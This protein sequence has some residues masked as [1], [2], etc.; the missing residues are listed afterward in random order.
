[1]Q[2]LAISLPKNHTF[3]AEIQHQWSSSVANSHFN[4]IDSSKFAKMWICEG[5]GVSLF[6]KRVYSRINSRSWLIAFVKVCKVTFLYSKHCQT[7]SQPIDLKLISYIALQPP[8]DRL[9][10]EWIIAVNELQC[11]FFF[12]QPLYNFIVFNLFR[13]FTVLLKLILKIIVSE[14]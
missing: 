9:L 7:T 6:W 13:C 2:I 8:I 10:I 1:M 11:S 14:N 4:S 3:K 12:S 5:R